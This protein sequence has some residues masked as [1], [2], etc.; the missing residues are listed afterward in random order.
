MPSINFVKNR[1]E[2]F[3]ST[4]YFVQDGGD[5]IGSVG[6]CGTDGIPV[7]ANK[8]PVCYLPDMDSVREFFTTLR[9]LK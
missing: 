5:Y 8:N 3:P 6:F 7:C 2:K 1:D 9:R 4:D